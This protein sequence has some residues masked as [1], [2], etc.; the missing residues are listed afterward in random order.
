VL[1]QVL[2]ADTAWQVWERVVG[3][4][5]EAQ[6]QLAA[7]RGPVLGTGIRE[8]S[9]STVPRLARA[10]LDELALLPRGCGG[11][12]PA[13]AARLYDALPRLD[14]W[15]AELA[16]SGLPDSVQ[17][18]DLHAGNVCWTGSAETARVIDW[19]DTVWGFPL[20]TMYTTMRSLAVHA[21][22][23]VGLDIG[24]RVGGERVEAR[25]VLRVRDAYLEP[26]TG[27]AD[28][29]DLVH[30]VDVARHTGC[31]GKALAFRAAMEGAPVSAQADLG[32]PVRACLS[33]LL[34]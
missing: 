9:A 22:L 6:V 17:H 14:S 13:E 7:E 31:V 2:T 10:L 4:Y 19:G 27:F 16:S 20:A 21:G 5:A 29:A 3:R 8:V 23:D 24:P 12:G 32:F 25:E 15:C 26:F 34:A 33:E 1:R 30:L 11:L 28:R 18:D